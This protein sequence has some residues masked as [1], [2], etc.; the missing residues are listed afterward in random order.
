MAYNEPM[1]HR[2]YSLK[3]LAL[4]TICCLS[5][6]MSNSAQAKSTNRALLIGVND[7][8]DAGIKDLSTAVNDATFVGQVLADEY[9]YEITSLTNENATKKNI[10]SSL[11]RLRSVATEN[12]NVVIYFAGHGQVDD[13]GAYWLPYDAEA[14]E[15]EGAEAAWI[16]SSLVRD[17][18][19][20]FKSRHVL[21]ISDSCFAGG[22]IST[23][24]LTGKSRYQEGWLDKV[25]KKKSRWILTSGSNEPVADTTEISADHS[26]FAY[27][28]IDA[29]KSMSNRPFTVQDL[30]NAVQR[31]VGNNSFQTPRAN[32]I[33]GA[34]D[35]GGQL[36]FASKQVI[37]GAGQPQLPDTNDSFQPMDMAS[38]SF[39]SAAAARSLRRRR[40]L[41]TTGLTSIALA[42]VNIAVAGWAK[43]KYLAADTPTDLDR[44]QSMNSGF[45]YSG[46]ALGVVGGALTTG[47]LLAPVPTSGGRPDSQPATD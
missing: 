22:L 4:A 34:G 13:V 21:I 3:L 38:L 35:L 20:A 10:Y 18:L 15:N 11:A 12:D 14:P 8:Q 6:A 39:A 31:N 26:V 43:Q 5:L 2:L 45:G 16:P 42:G 24:G 33:I 41:M 23:R 19:A 27:F 47:A 40:T 32:A 9:G 36:V 46:I 37:A 1:K 29:L 28:L 30:T 25:N 44:Y 7:Y 17:N